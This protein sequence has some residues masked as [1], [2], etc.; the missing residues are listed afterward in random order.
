M[1]LLMRETQYKNWGTEPLI[2]F[3][4]PSCGSSI[5]ETSGKWPSNC[6]HCSKELPQMYKHFLKRKM[7]RYI[8]YSRP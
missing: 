8:Y 5:I 1:A 3:M 6:W 4:C 7:A 2:E